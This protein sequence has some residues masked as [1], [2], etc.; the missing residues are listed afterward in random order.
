[1]ANY[2]NIHRAQWR[3]EDIGDSLY[4]F[5]MAYS[6]VNAAN[7]EF[8]KEQI[9]STNDRIRED[10]CRLH[11]TLNLIEGQYMARTEVEDKY[12]LKQIEG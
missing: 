4:Q 10:L 8:W 12:V 6:N 11:E 3:V 2:N 5:E 1:M 7:L 9:E